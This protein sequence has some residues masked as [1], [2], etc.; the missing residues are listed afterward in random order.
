MH[1]ALF[2]VAAAA[3]LPRAA[4]ASCPPLTLP[5][6]ESLLTVGTRTLHIY[7]P[8]TYD[9]SRASS[10][11]I[12][13]HGFTDS[14]DSFGSSCGEKHCNFFAAA[15]KEA[16]IFASLCGELGDSSFNAGTCCPP[17][18]TVEVDDVGFARAAVGNI[19]SLLC[20]DPAKVFST[21][22]SN[23]AMMSQRLACE[24]S[25]LF[26]AVASVAGVVELQPG[27]DEGLKLCNNSF[28]NGSKNISVLDVHGLDDDVVPIGGDAIL[29]FPPIHEN[30]YQW[31]GRNMCSSGP[32]PAWTNGSYASTKWTGC[33]VGGDREVELVLYAKGTHEWP[34]PAP[35]FTTTDYV[36][37]F[38]RRRAGGHL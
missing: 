4:A 12:Y 6:G 36:V 15:E 28:A 32:T 37:D 3:I 13:W 29:G 22:F 27:N 38:F 30:M 18:N 35:E 26:A 34:P 33:G 11:I 17:A 19:S 16:F 10:L 9:A 24:A 5:R 25:D 2:V 31:A 21:G 20:I 14:C 8:Q 23:G 7:V 1:A